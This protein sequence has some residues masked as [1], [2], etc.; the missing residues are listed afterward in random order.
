MEVFDEGIYI[1]NSSDVDITGNTITPTMTEFFVIPSFVTNNTSVNIL[2]AESSLNTTYDYIT[3]TLPFTFNYM[4]RNI[5][6]IIANVAGS[7][8]LLEDGESCQACGYGGI[9]RNSLFA[10]TI[11]ASYDAITTEGEGNYVAVFNQD[12]EKV[13]VEWRGSTLADSDSVSHPIHFQVVMHPTGDVEWNFMQMDFESTYNPMFTGAYDVEANELYRAGIDINNASS[14]RADLSGNDDFVSSSSFDPIVGFSLQDVSNSSFIG[15]DIRA[16]QWVDAIAIENVVFNDSDSGNT[17]RLT[18][19]NGAWTVFDIVDTNGNGYA[20]SG[21]DRPFN[22]QVL[23]EEYW[24]GEGEDLYPRSIASGP[25]TPTP[26]VSG[27]AVQSRVSGGSV[28]TGNS[29]FSI[30]KP[31]QVDKPINRPLVSTTR[32]LQRFLN[33]NGFP[34]ALSGPG[35]LNNETESFGTLTRQALIRF[36]RANGI[37]PAVGIFGPITRAF[38][39]RTVSSSPTQNTTARATTSPTVIDNGLDLEVGSTGPSVV[40]LQEILIKLGF[41]IPDGA[42]GR[43]GQQTRNALASYQKANNIVPASGRLGPATRAY[44]KNTGIAGLWW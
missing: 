11:F 32:E 19:G 29:V 28:S 34:V 36:Q 12:D 42:T 7:I 33:T 27:F 24:S 9:Y 39:N 10:D 25:T 35:S 43:F 40:A 2:D 14:F 1:S 15:N 20:E 3:Y 41:K 21:T 26:T 4:G 18:N 23:G 16:G 44:M 13:I 30:K 37:S 22:Q 38:I 17:Y 31:A 8:E 6:T 5:T